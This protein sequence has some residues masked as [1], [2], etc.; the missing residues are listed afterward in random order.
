MPDKEMIDKLIILLKEFKAEID[1]L[2]FFE[3]L[4]RRYNHIV[5]HIGEYV[6]SIIRTKPF[7]VIITLIFF[8]FISVFCTNLIL[9]NL[10]DVVSPLILVSLLNIIMYVCQIK[11]IIEDTE[12]YLLSEKIYFFFVGVNII[13]L[14]LLVYRI[15]IR[16]MLRNNAALEKLST[17]FLLNCILIIIYILF[18]IGYYY[19]KNLYILKEQLKAYNLHLTLEAFGWYLYDFKIIEYVSMLVIVMILLFLFVRSI[20]FFIYIRCI[21]LLLIL[22]YVILP[23][24]LISFDIIF[25]KLLYSIIIFLMIE[26]IIFVISVAEFDF[27]KCIKNIKS[28]KSIKHKKR[29]KRKK[30]I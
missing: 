2:G 14:C 30:R 27:F 26:A 3:A 17:I 13:I 28:I 12:I 20:Y 22:L 24:R 5:A 7:K 6:I 19:F 29:K 16:P 8:Y 18:Y 23:F 11:L 9:A 4:E 10:S 21:I 25:Q 1:S 15:F